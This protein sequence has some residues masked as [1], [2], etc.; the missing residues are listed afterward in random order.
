MV[1]HGTVDRTCSAPVS[2]VLAGA[3]SACAGGASASGAVVAGLTL[4]VG[5]VSPL[6]SLVFGPLENRFPAFRD[7]GMPVT[8]IVVLGGAVETGLSTAAASS[9][10]TM[11]ASA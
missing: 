5:G 6:A 4:L 8:G 1:P 11:P 7:D 3:D 9:S 2:L 10:S